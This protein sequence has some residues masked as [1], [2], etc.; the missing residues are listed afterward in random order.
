MEFLIAAVK[1]ISERYTYQ[2]GRVLQSCNISRRY[3]LRLPGKALADVREYDDI[4]K[5]AWN[6]MNI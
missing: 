4:S 2:P 3:T 6:F 5:V 1:Y